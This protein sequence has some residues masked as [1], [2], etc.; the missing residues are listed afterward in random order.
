[1]SVSDGQVANASTFNGAF[2]SKTANSTTIGQITLNNADTS[3]GTQVSNIQ[4]EFNSFSSYTGKN[5]N[6]AKDALPA[7]SDNTIGASSDSLFDRIEAIQDQFPVS[8]VSNVDGVLPIVNGG[9]NKSAVNDDQVFFGQFEQASGLVFES[10]SGF[11]GIGTSAP[12]ATLDVNGTINMRAGD[13]TIASGVMNDVPNALVRVVG[14]SVDYGSTTLLHTIP[15]PAGN[16]N[17]VK[18]L[19]NTL[20]F[21][22]TI[23]DAGNIETNGDEIL[24]EDNNLILMVWDWFDDIWRILAGGG[25]GGSAPTITN[26][27]N[28]GGTTLTATTALEQIWRF[29]GPTTAL[30]LTAIDFSAM[31]QGGILKVTSQ[32]DSTYPI[33]IPADLSNVIMNGEWVGTQYSLI[34][35]QR[36]GPRIIEVSRNG[37]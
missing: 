1:M 35:F 3:S 33:T 34:V 23:T 4:R 20:G 9:T 27:D 2:I 26:F 32:E 21:D 12:L 7:W 22:I 36:I 29:T 19:A 28:T 24:L 37:I 13:G 10:A 31:E 17:E 8:L 5:L 30:T 11:L 15:A 18:I 14:G 6:A 25:G 16:A